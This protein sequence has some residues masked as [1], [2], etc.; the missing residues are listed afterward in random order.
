M[1]GGGRGGGRKLKFR[2]K[3]FYILL[4]ELLHLM[5]FKGRINYNQIFIKQDKARIN[6]FFYGLCV[7]ERERE[8]ESER[9]YLLRIRTYLNLV[10]TILVDCC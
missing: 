2:M 9:D 5:K 6:F 10:E 7:C 3:L 8:T 1:A 4:V